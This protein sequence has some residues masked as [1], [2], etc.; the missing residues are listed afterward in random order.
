MKKP[1]SEGGYGQAWGL[2]DRLA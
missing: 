2:E 1:E